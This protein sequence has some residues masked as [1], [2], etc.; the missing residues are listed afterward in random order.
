MSTPGVELI[1]LPP[2]DTGRERARARA[3][4]RGAAHV[5]RSYRTPLAAIAWHSSPVGVDLERVEPFTRSFAESICTPDELEQ[6]DSLAA[7][8]ELVASLWSG[9]EALAKA[10]GDALA[11][12]PR[13]LQSPLMW[14]DGVCGRWRAR[15]L[16]ALPEGY[17]GWLVWSEAPAA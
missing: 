12:D 7:R 5:S 15:A 17:V 2:G 6:I 13:R 4:A 3:R 9:K 10:L 14:P 16:E 1:E 8:D 11:Y